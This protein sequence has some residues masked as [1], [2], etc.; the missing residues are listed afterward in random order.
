L[1]GPDKSKIKNQNS[2]QGNANQTG[3]IE[4]AEKSFEKIL[5]RVAI[6]TLYKSARANEDD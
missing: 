4:R 2:P 6:A 5:D 1:A 3:L